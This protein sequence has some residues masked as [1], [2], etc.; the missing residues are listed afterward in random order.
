MVSL[1][2]RTTRCEIAGTAFGEGGAD[3]WRTVRQSMQ[4]TSWYAAYFTPST[5]ES[6]GGFPGEYRFVTILARIGTEIP[7][8]VNP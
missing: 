1:Q 4:E 2:C 3:A 5:L 8:P 7:P 6:G